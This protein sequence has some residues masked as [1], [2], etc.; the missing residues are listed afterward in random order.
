MREVA[1]TA[2]YYALPGNQAELGTKPYI[3]FSGFFASMIKGSST[4]SLTSYHVAWWGHLVTLLFFSNYVPWSK[5]S[6]V[7]AAPLQYLLHGP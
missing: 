6:H 4:E 7:F 3:W 5:H 2:C 1:Q